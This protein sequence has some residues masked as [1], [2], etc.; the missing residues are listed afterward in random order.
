MK[1]F[2]LA[3]LWSFLLMVAATASAQTSGTFVVG[4]DLD[5]FYPVVWK[6]NGWFANTA[7]ELE[8]GRAD[9]HRDGGNEWRGSLLAKFRY[10]VTNWGNGS[11][12]IEADIHQAG[13][14]YDFIAGWRDVTGFNNANEIIIWLRGNTS[15]S[16]TSRYAIEA[17]AVFDGVA[18]PLPLTMLNEPPHTFKTSVDGYVNRQGRTI[19]SLYLNGIVNWTAYNWRKPLRLP[20]GQAIAFDAGTTKIGLGGVGNKLY[21]FTTDV[22]DASKV[23]NYRLIMNENG[24]MGIGTEPVT[25]FRMVVEGSLGARRIKVAQGTWADFVFHDDYKLPSLQETEAFI[26]VNKH[27][28]DI[29]SEKEVVEKGVDV[30]EMNKLLLQ[31]I[32]EM[33]L[34]MIK[35]EKRIQELESRQEK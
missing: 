26:K 15:Y 9:V 32:E 3:L 35:M 20:T 27:L 34:H 29:P 21:L 17:P 4:G 1:Y 16:Y 31:K 30:G 19:G 22:E 7:S 12:F 11:D 18:N 28:P 33:T 10:H 2:S 13:S 25:G 8:I 5:K 6:D 14:A 23:P 24:E